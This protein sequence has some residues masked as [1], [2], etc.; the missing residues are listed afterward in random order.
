[1]FRGRAVKDLRTWRALYERACNMLAE[2]QGDDFQRIA[3]AEEF[4]TKRGNRMFAESGDEMRT[5]Y[6]V[7]PGVWAE[8]NLSANNIRDRIREL[9][10]FFGYD[11]SEFRV[12]LRE[13]RDAE[14]VGR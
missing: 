10:E 8:M 4:A 13:D 3:T 11:W 6:E 2:L 14:A 7:G 12:Y 1:M 5:A 9:L